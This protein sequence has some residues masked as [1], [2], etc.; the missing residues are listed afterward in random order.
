MGQESTAGKDRVMTGNASDIEIDPLSFSLGM[1][2]CF[3]EMVACGVKRLA[4]SPPL[5]PEDYDRLSAASDEIVS[6]FGI[7][8]YLEKSLMVT[9]L[10][11]PDFTLGKYSI[12][13]FRER[14][15][16]D[17]YLA[18][19]RRKESLEQDGRYDAETRRAI[20]RDF[21]RL[22]SYPEA[23][24]DEKLAKAPTDPYVHVSS[25]ES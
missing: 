12:L 5:T 11:T 22:L 9:D 4:L 3:V 16:L 10:Q 6:R 21:M 1:I 24:I 2:N 15:T 19:K 17:A 8:S 25:G 7:Q 23:I 20:S 14:A 18:L 13:Y